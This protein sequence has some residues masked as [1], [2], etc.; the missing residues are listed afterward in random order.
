MTTRRPL[1]LLVLFALCLSSANA[2]FLN[3]NFLETVINRILEVLGTFG[4]WNSV[5]R[6][7]CETFQDLLP[8][9]FLDCQCAGSYKVGQG[10]GGEFF[11]RLGDEV[12][13][14]EGDS[15]D[16]DNL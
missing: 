7:L 12:C 15:K 11:C 16:E 4:L 14:L 1:F 2:L 13:L 6:S 10:L 5:A 9:V 3:L 8:D